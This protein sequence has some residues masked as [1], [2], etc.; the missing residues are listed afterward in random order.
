MVFVERWQPGPT[1]VEAGPEEETSGDS[2]PLLHPGRA[3][4]AQAWQLVAQWVQS[5]LE[6]LGAPVVAKAIW[7]L[8]SSA[9]RSISLVVEREKGRAPLKKPAL[10]AGRVLLPLLKGKAA[11]PAPSTGSPA[12]FT[13]WL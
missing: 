7:P 5:G 3:V 9:P 6:D 1:R 11:T 4:G 12:S 10:A 13:S 2:L 8:P